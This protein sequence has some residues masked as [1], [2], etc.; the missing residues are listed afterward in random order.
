M[1]NTDELVDAYLRYKERKDE[2]LWAFEEMDNLV[3]EKPLEAQEIIIKLI[4][5]AP[6][7]KTLAFIAAGPLEDLL[8]HHGEKVIDWAEENTRQNN[9]F[10]KALSCV[11]KNNIKDGVWERIV[12]LRKPVS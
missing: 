2:D 10:A 9:K 11:W 3:K 12:K 7:D 5:K 4:T 6:D 8:V 1:K